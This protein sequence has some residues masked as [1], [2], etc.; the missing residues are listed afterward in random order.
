MVNTTLNAP[1]VSFR[2]SGNPVAGYNFAVTGN[3]RV[4]TISGKSGHIV[5]MLYQNDNNSLR[6]FINR[7]DSPNNSC[8]YRINDNGTWSPSATTNTMCPNTQNILTNGLDWNATFHFIYLQGKTSLYLEGKHI[9]T[10]EKDW[11]YA[12]AILW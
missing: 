6:Y 2:D 11:G 12:N 8:Y 1:M 5:F 9:M 3:I 4:K 10:Y 7:N